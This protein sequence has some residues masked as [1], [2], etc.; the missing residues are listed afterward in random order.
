MT[1]TRKVEVFTAGCFICA[2]AVK[3]IQDIVCSNCDVTV[4]DLSNKC[5]TEECVDKA[6]KYGI[7]S[8]PALVVDGRLADCCRSRG[9]DVSVV[10]AAGLG[11]R[12]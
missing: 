3:T 8:L 2:E 11:Q 12:L 7:R 5:A 10:K 6:K 4:Y 1:K 9:I